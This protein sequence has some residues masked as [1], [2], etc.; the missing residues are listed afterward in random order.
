MHA[1]LREAQM[2]HSRPHWVLRRIEHSPAKSGS[3][4]HAWVCEGAQADTAT[5]LD[6]QTDAPSRLH[7]RLLTRAASASVR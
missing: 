4:V 3:G 1:A 7:A 5:H 6:S 2:Y